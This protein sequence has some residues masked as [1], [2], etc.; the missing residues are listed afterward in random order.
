[1]LSKNTEPPDTKTVGDK[2]SLKMPQCKCHG[3]CATRLWEVSNHEEGTR[4]K[5][6]QDDTSD[7]R[8]SQQM[9]TVI[10]T[11]ESGDPGKVQKELQP[12]GPLTF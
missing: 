1:M 11:W 4:A 9:L 2:P 6:G 5:E 7:Q 12:P 3:T 10:S 8:K